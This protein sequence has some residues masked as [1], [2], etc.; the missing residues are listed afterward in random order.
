M[1][2]SSNNTFGINTNLEMSME[3]ATLLKIF[4][5]IV[6]ALLIN[7]ILIKIINP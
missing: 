5:A 7:Q 2:P 3:T 6:A 4:V 1:N